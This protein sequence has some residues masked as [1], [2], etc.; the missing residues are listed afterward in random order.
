M[1]KVAVS[2]KE[3]TNLVTQDMQ[4]SKAGSSIGRTLGMTL[5]YT[6]TPEGKAM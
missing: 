5:S 1:F 4:A 6:G 2:T 3:A